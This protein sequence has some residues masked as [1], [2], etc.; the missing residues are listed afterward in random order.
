MVSKI[1]K[2]TKQKYVGHFSAVAK[3]SIPSYL[4]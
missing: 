2:L 3:K 1:Y 4:S